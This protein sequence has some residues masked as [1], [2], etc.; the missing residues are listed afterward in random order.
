MGLEN[1]MSQGKTETTAAQGACMIQAP[2]PAKRKR[3][4]IADATPT[5]M[6]AVTFVAALA[7]HVDEKR[8]IITQNGTPETQSR[9]A[10]DLK[11]RFK[12]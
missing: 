9:I 10:A 7:Q 2:S 5:E 4:T 11:E 8:G 6:A 3:R 12:L 1:V